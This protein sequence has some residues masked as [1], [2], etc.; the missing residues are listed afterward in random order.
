MECRS[1]GDVYLL[2]KSS[3]FVTHD[4][5]CVFDGCVDD[6]D[7]E[8]ESAAGTQSQEQKG[9]DDD[10]ETTTTALS[11]LSLSTI[12]YHLVLRK[13]VLQLNPALEFRCFVRD[14][15]LIGICQREQ[16]HFDF[17]F[18]HRDK[19]RSLIQL[20]FDTRLRDTFPDPSFA[21][22]VYIPPPHKRV[23]LIDINPWAPRTDPLLFEWMELLT[24]PGPES[25]DEDDAVLVKEE[26][27]IKKEKARKE[28]GGAGAD[29]D[30]ETEIEEI[31]RYLPEF[32]LIKR[33]DPEAYSFATR[34]YGAHKLPLEVV[35]ACSG[36]EGQLEDFASKWK[37]IV[38]K[39][40][41][42]DE[43]SSDEEA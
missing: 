34:K 38:Q 37:E 14:R 23:W 19:F 7:T 33:D 13:T 3:D 12:P 22:D 4:L 25:W 39:R 29:T 43:A 6:D 42:D 17:L 35:A 36:G 10:L 16:N 5:E 26:H 9:V 21:F 28:N 24:M 40:Q 30:S 31:S 32:R 41:V 27:K 2:L 15:G 20:F 8:E 1:P 18:P 11:S